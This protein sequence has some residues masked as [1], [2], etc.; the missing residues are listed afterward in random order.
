MSIV[1][2]DNVDANFQ[3]LLKILCMLIFG[4]SMS[5]IQKFHSIRK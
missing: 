1:S 5:K 3:G 4:H 2:F